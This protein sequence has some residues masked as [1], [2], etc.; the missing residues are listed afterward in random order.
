MKKWFGVLLLIVL[1]FIAAAYFFIPRSSSLQAARSVRVNARA[2]SR[3][4]MN[5]DNW[6]KWW[7]GKMVS[8]GKHQRYQ[9][10]DHEYYIVDQRINSFIILI[11]GKNISDTTELQLLPTAPDSVELVWKGKAAASGPFSKFSS[12]STAKILNR[13]LKLV[14]DHIADYYTNQDNLYGISIKEDKVVDSTLLQ[15]FTI[16]NG[17]PSTEL[18]YQLIDEA[19]QYARKNGAKETGFP[20]LNI[21]TPDTIRYLAKIA[22]P[23]DKQL[24]P[25]GN[26]AYKWMLPR[27]NILVA[28]IK[29]GPGAIKNAFQHMD[30]YITDHQRLAPAIPF[31]SLITDRLQEKD[32]SKWVTRIY[33]PVM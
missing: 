13:E 6:Q 32:T 31:Q 33:Y 12:W 30:E 20:M 23:V 27:G 19:R 2:F 7:P 15:N 21:S 5:E 25:S 8:G 18:V 1:L 10:N 11:S 29:G 22:I 9:F 26:L 28:E 14:L 17:Y 16:V 4:F 3:N 24:P